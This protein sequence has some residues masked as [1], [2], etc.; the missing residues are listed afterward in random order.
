MSDKNEELI[1]TI[2]TVLRG[3]QRAMA[4]SE[5][6]EKLTPESEGDWEI[7]T[8]DEVHPFELTRVKAFLRYIRDLGES[9]ELDVDKV[10]LDFLEDFVEKCE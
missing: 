7:K 4:I 9:G 3:L 10:A 8:G 6:E 1:R 2:A 5:D